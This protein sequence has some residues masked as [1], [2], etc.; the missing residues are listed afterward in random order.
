MVRISFTSNACRKARSLITTTQT[1]KPTSHSTRRGFA[2]VSST[3]VTSSSGNRQHKVVVVGAGSAGLCISHQLLRTG[4]FGTHDIAIIDPAQWH[5]YQPGWTLVGAGL[6]NK[7]D[8]KRPVESLLDPKLK[9]Y[10]TGVNTFSPDQNS[11]NL[12]NGDNL[13]YEQLVVAPG[14]K[15]NYDSIKGL[16]EALANKDSLVSSI[17]GYET[18]DKVFRTIE[19][20]K[21]GNAIFTHP[22]GVVKCAGAPQKIMWLALDHW[23]KEGLYNPKP[24]SKSP[25][26]INI[27]F[28]T[29]LPGMFGVPKYSQALNELRQERNVEGLFQ[30]D[31]IAIEGN[32]AVFSNL[33]TEGEGQVVKRHFDLLHAVPKMGPHPFI[34]TSPLA[35]SA[36]FVDVDESTL[37]H[38]KYPNVWSAGDASSLP[39]SKTAAAITGQAPVLVANLLRTMEGKPVEPEYN[40]YTSCPLLTEYGKVMLAEFKYGG[41]PEE[42]F[43]KWFGWDQ[44]VPRRAFYHLKKDFFP[45]VYYNSMVKGT[46]AGPKGWIRGPSE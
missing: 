25:S 4:K 18:C 39:T 24:D 38:K 15:I 19:A 23:T 27:T 2:S 40:G 45:W 14:I 32:T 11:V 33:N 5:H 17:Y 28:A 46:W 12:S 29:A 3:A 20:L 43:N 36:G 10:N 30:H 44:A 13:T 6:K 21:K 1:I 26:A 22:T 34:A 16:P 35:N 8:L 37:Q 41:V 9:F 42:T 31:L 7:E